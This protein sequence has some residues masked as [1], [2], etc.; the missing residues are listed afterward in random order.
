MSE[1]LNASGNRA[2]EGNRYWLVDGL[3][4]GRAKLLDAM[5][6]SM[7]ES[8]LTSAALV[9]DLSDNESYGLRASRS[10]AELYL[11]TAGAELPL[12]C[13]AM[14]QS[15]GVAGGFTLNCEEFW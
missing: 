1:P 5:E 7:T 11:K 9:I 13:Q 3:K 12:F 15:I 6:G 14:L 4:R 10:P 2:K 8:F